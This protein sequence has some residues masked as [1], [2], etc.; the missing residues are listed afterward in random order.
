MRAR[1]KPFVFTIDANGITRVNQL[2]NMEIRDSNRHMLWS[3]H[4]LTVWG[5]VGRIRVSSEDD[6]GLR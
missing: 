6:I 3:S 1:R 4:I 5:R 2:F